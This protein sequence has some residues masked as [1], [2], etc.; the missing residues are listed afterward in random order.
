MPVVMITA[1]AGMIG[2][3]VSRRLLKDGWTVV[4]TDIKPDNLKKIAALVG[5]P[6][7]VETYT[8][9]VT[10]LAQVQEVVGNILARHGRIDGL[11]NIAGG[12]TA[13]GVPKM[14]FTEMPPEMWDITIGVNF[15]GMLNCTHTILPHMI[16]QKKGVI[17]NTASGSG[18]RGGPP[19]THQRGATTYCMIK[20]AVIAFTQSLAQEVGPHG[21]RVNCYAPGNSPS[22]WKSLEMIQEYQKVEDAKKKGSGRGSPL[23]RILMNTDLANTVSFLMSDRASHVTGSCIDMTGGIRLW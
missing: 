11:V 3:G 23:G 1:A 4:M 2:E 16:G 7:Q 12:S 15:K 17:V 5:E 9:D 14:E 22:R 13:I 8:L 6:P 19:H 20:G 21:I 10:D 18:I